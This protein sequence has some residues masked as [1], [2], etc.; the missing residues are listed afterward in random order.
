M[1]PV[2]S[3]NFGSNGL[4]AVFNNGS[5]V[6]SGYIVKQIGTN[7]FVVTDGT[8]TNGTLNTFIRT[9]AQSVSDATSLPTTVFTINTYPVSTTG[10]GASL[11][12]TYQLASAAVATG[13]TGYVVNGTLTTSYGTLTITS[14]GT[15]G[16]L[17]GLSLTSA[18]T[19]TSLPTNPV[20]PAGGSGTGATLTLMSEV[21]AVAATGGSAYVANQSVVFEFPTGATVT[22]P[23]AHVS[24]VGTTGA[25][26]AIAVDTAGLVTAAP[27]SVQIGGAVEHVA[28]IYSS[29]VQ[30]VEGNSYSW[31]P[32]ATGTGSTVLG[33]KLNG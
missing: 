25:I 10:T 18:G 15:L 3:H 6:V 11:A 8:T 9:L 4:T 24:S 20:S 33:S 31:N 23:A 29:K 7:K 19:Y 30:T 28:H 22:A 1:H 13:G 2:N 5:G 14:V 32:L 12:V 21:T 16:A 17:T 26:T 27:T